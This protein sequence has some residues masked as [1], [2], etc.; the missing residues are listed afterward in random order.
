MAPGRGRSQKHSGTV[1]SFG[2]YGSGISVYLAVTAKTTV[3]NAGLKAPPRSLESIP[4]KNESPEETVIRTRNGGEY[5][6]T[7]CDRTRG[8][9]VCVVG[10]AFE[11]MISVGL[12]RMRPS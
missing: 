10:S 3:R 11:G 2:G 6:Y 4:R 9:A 12:R 5:R 1:G 7:V 8:E